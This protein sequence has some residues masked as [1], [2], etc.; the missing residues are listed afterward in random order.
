MQVVNEA[1]SCVEE[2]PYLMVNYT[3]PG[4]SPSSVSI[5]FENCSLAS[6]G[7][8]NSSANTLSYVCGV[9]EDGD[10]TCLDEHTYEVRV[11][12]QSIVDGEVHFSDYSD[13]LSLQ[14]P[15]ESECVWIHVNSA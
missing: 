6:S 10:S 7:A 4:G 5:N 3:R 1:L 9:T 11:A 13:P 8:S 2:P 14:A 15:N 12:Y